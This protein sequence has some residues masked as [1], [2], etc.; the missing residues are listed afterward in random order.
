MSLK[1][2]S[3]NVRGLADGKK[4]RQIFHYL[5]EKQIDVAFIQESHSTKNSKKLWKNVW[6]GE[7][8]FAHGESNSL[9]VC[10]LI[11]PKSSIKIIK[12]KTVIEGRVLNTVIEFENQKILLSNVY[13]PNVDDVNFFEQLFNSLSEEEVDETIVGGDWNVVLGDSRKNR[14]KK[15]NVVVIST[16]G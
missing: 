14:L 8:A 2:I 1:I 13:A 9:G 15:Q 11:N 10:T 6:R 16:R 3:C 4:R 5:W 7:I 12:E